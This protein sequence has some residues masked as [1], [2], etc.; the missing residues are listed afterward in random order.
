MRPA[1]GSVVPPDHTAELTLALAVCTLVRST[2][3]KDSVPEVV[4]ALLEPVA[5]ATSLKACGPE[6]SA[7]RTGASLVPVIVMVTGRVE[8]SVPSETVT[9]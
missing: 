2:S 3:V 8:L 1:L 4:S 9:S 5:P 7:A 6:T